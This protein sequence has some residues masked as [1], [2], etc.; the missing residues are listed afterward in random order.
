M[1]QENPNTVSTDPGNTTNYNPP[2]RSLLKQAKSREKI[3]EVD[4]PQKVPRVK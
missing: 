4:K 3:Y 1:A 2:W